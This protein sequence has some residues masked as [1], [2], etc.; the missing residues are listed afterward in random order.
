[1]G[2]S[3]PQQDHDID[4]ISAWLAQ[5][6][7]LLST[8]RRAGNPGSEAL[9]RAFNIFNDARR[10]IRSRALR[11]A[12]QVALVGLGVAGTLLVEYLNQ[13]NDPSIKQWIG[14]LFVALPSAVV[15]GIYLYESF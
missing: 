10:P 8:A 5:Q 7:K 11:T 13:S 9:A 3:E 1:M 15:Y 4:E 12:S 14:F 2:G 6:S